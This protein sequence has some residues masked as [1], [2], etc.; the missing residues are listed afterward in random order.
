MTKASKPSHDH[1]TEEKWHDEH[2]P[3]TN[4]RN[5]CVVL[6]GEKPPEEVLFIGPNGVTH[7]RVV[8]E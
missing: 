1:L 7:Y 2:V 4:P 3:R 6:E 8:S 5:T